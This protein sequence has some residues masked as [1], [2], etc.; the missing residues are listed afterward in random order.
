VC[1]GR[2][3]STYKLKSIV[4]SLFR[5]ETLDWSYQ[6]GF[7]VRQIFVKIEIKLCT[8]QDPRTDFDES[9]C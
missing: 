1:D 2:E 4:L 7:S 9:R 5:T 6:S 8:R 3:E